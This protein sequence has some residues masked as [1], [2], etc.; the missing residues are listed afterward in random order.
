[1]CV[2]GEGGRE[3]EREKERERVGEEQKREY[4]HTRHEFLV[5]ESFVFW[6]WFHTSLVP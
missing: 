4:V 2:R 6:A 3:R 1:M 5:I